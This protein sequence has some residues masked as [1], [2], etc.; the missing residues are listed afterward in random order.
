MARNVGTTNGEDWVTYAPDVD[1]NRE[2][3]T[4]LTVELHPMS[5]DELRA[6]Q[7]GV[8][9]AG[10]KRALATRAEKVSERIY[11]ERVRNV[12]TYSVNGKPILTGADL[13]QHGEQIV[14]DDIW[15]ALTNLSQLGEGLVGNSSSRPAS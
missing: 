12:R 3:E 13:Y 15:T 11:S 9:T 1:G 6:Y 7:R 10:S 5:G 14:R 4:P 8:V 2:D